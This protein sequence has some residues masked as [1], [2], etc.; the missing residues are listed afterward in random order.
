MIVFLNGSG[1]EL[2]LTNFGVPPFLPFDN[3]MIWSFKRRFLTIQEA[4]PR[5]RLRNTHLAFRV[6][7]EIDRISTSQLNNLLRGEAA[8]IVARHPS[9][10]GIDL[11]VVTDCCF[12]EMFLSYSFHRTT[13]FA[14]AAHASNFWICDGIIKGDQTKEICNALYPEIRWEC[15]VSLLGHVSQNIM[16]NDPETPFAVINNGDTNYNKNTAYRWVS[17]LTSKNMKVQDMANESAS[18]LFI[19]FERSSDNAPV[20]LPNGL[21]KHCS[22]LGALV[23]FSC[24]FNFASPPFLQC[25][26]LRFLGLERCTHDLTSKGEESK[27]WEYLDKLWVLDLRHTNWYEILS[28][29]KIGLMVISRS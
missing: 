26:G 2:D 29:E 24:A 18:S 12:Y 21:F 23:L 25:R 16:Q 1:V 9:I 6:G 27:N 20:G 5:S 15:D 7:T 4:Y 22:N 14:W 28:E 11:T 17:L 19:A 8:S 10:Q 13:G 3:I